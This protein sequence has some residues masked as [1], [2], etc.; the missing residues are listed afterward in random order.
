MINSG[1]MNEDCICFFMIV[2]FVWMKYII[3]LWCISV[4]VCSDIF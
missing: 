3:L 4:V 1:I 2:L